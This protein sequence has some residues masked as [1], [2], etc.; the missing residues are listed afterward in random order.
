MYQNRYIR[1]ITVALLFGSA[2]FL[3]GCKGNLDGD[4][5]IDDSKKIPSMVSDNLTITHYE[6]GRMTY[7]FYTLK[8]ERYDFSDAPYMEFT[9]GI[10]IETFD[11]LMKKKSDL[12]ADYAKYIEKDRLWEVK[13]NVFGSDVTGK[14]IITEQL[15]WNERTDK[16]YSNVDT[17]VINGEEVTVGSGFESDGSMQDI[18]F[19]QTKGRILVDTAKTQNP[20]DTLSLSPVKPNPQTV[21]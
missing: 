16:I 11:S 3:C 21:Q 18:T 15:F 5:T 12:V 20:V 14:S 4:I 8:M 17:K 19:R 13:G 7:K 6:D 1:F 2:I 9:K 10:K